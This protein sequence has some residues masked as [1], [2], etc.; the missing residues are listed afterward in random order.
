MIAVVIV[1]FPSLVSVVGLL[2]AAAVRR[3]T[4]LTGDRDAGSFRLD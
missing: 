2:N 3:L 1:E 4:G